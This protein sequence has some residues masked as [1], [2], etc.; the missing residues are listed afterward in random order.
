MPVDEVVPGDVV[1]L[2]A[3]DTVPGDCLLLESKD[4]FVDEAT[5]TGETYPVEKICGVL[6]TDIPLARR[7]NSLF[8]GTHV[9][10]G[11]STAVVVHIGSDTEFGKVSGRLQL[12]PPETEFERGIRQF[13]Y[14]LLEVTVVLVVAIF[15]VN[16]YLARPVLEAFLFSLALVDQPDFHQSV[17]DR[18]VDRHILARERIALMSIDIST[19]HLTISRII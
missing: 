3:G 14:L 2:R 13:G 17:V 19:I 5:L 11:N 16:V 7:T 8:L 9:V 18:A 15:A 4:L 12:R 1:L 6:P 10:S